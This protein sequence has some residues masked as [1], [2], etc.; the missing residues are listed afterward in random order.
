V[1][2]PT[3]NYEKSIF[4]AIDAFSHRRNDCER[5]LQETDHNVSNSHTRFQRAAGNDYVDN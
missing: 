1:V 2:R 4:T 3:V 5:G